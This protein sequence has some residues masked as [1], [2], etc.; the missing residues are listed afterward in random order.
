[1]SGGSSAE[2]HPSIRH[3]M[4]W[5]G[6]TL[7]RGY[8]LGG[9]TSISPKLPATPA[10]RPSVLPC[11]CEMARQMPP[12]IG[13]KRSVGLGLPRYD[14]RCMASG[15]ASFPRLRDVGLYS[16]KPG[17]GVHVRAPRIM[18]SL[19]TLPMVPSTLHLRPVGF[20][21]S[22]SSCLPP[23]RLAPGSTSTQLRPDGLDFLTSQSAVHRAVAYAAAAAAA[24]AGRPADRP[25]GTYLICRGS[26]ELFI[27]TTR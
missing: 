2:G 10:F 5:H 27:P 18:L 19:R 11:G 7:P 23:S 17:P 4:A 12:S 8:V 16:S 20:A 22:A 15:T 3:G 21:L 14:G 24:A 1:M 25:T 6:D 9:R 13:V 26:M